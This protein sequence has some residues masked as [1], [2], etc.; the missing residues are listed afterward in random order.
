MREVPNHEEMHSGENIIETLFRW[1][2]EWQAAIIK[3]F[4]H[5][6]RLLHYIVKLV[7]GPILFV[8]QN[9]LG[10]WVELNKGL[11]ERSIAVGRAIEHIQLAPGID[12]G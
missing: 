1:N 9:D 2:R 4:K 3:P 5:E 12:V 7:G 11:T 8:W 10:D 6:G